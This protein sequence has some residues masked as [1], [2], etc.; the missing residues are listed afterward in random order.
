M[1]V[2]LWTAPN[3]TLVATTSPKLKELSDV[4]GTHHPYYIDGVLHT[5]D[6]S[7]MELLAVFAGRACYQ[8]FGTSA[9]RQ[10]AEEYLGHIL[11]AKH[12]SVLE[13]ASVT[14]YIQ[15]VSRSLTHELVRHR[16]FSFSQLSQRYVSVEDHIG[17]VVPPAY[18]PLND[19]DRASWTDEGVLAQRKYQT[20]LAIATSQGLEGKQAREAARAVLPN[21]VETKIVVTGNL[22]SWYEFLEKRDSPHAD[23]E[24]QRLAKVIREKL[25]EEA[26]LIFKKEED[27]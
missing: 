8:S 1:T 7:D 4:L 3:V 13:H 18:V 24:M 5:K 6:A 26:P 2:T 17:V 11:D 23:A 16:H 22:R 15:G 14:F 12:M 20:E 27:Q 19:R 25:H 10:S 21:F 9:G